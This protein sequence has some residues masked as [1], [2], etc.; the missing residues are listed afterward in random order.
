MRMRT[1]RW[2][3]VVLA[4]FLVLL[5]AK[6]FL[7]DTAA[8]PGANYVIDVAALHR[9]A[10][11]SGPLP[12]R[13]E[14]EQVAEFAFPRTMVVAGDGFR[15]HAMVLLAYR[16]VGQAGSVVI[17]TAM[18]PS[19]IAKLPGSEAHPAAFA[20]VEQAMKQASAIVF[21]HEHEDHVWGVAAAENPAAISK[22][23]RMTREQLTSPNLE[24]SHFPKG[25]LEK[26]VPL[27]YAGLYSLAP[28]IVLQKAP[29]H[30]AGSQLVYV[31]LANG[32]RYLFVGDIAW[33]KDNIRLQLGRPGIASLVMKEDRPAVAAQLKTLARLPADVHVV[34][35]H[36][37]VALREDLRAGLYR[38]GFS[39]L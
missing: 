15:L 11:A 31:E 4:L 13:I 33:T 26:L 10:T 1:R 9:V 22:Q 14:V 8:T 36:D 32:Q 18:P 2:P 7:I 34:V 21:T 29:G 20:R 3:W 12:E 27:D 16:V 19:A 17:D 39:G 5:I 30:S 24:R 23:V 28:G 37:P 35:S 6:H 25:V 38:L